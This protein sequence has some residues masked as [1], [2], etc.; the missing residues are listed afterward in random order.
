[1]KSTRLLTYALTLPIWWALLLPGTSQAQFHPAIA[2]SYEPSKKPFYFGV[3]SGDPRPN[4]VLLWTKLVAEPPGVQTVT[5]EI[6]TDTAMTEVVQQGVTTT[7]PSSAYTVK[8]LVNGLQPGTYYYYRFQNG[9]SYSAVGRTKTAPG[10]EVEQLRLAVVSCVNYTSGYFNALEHLAQR[11]DI[12]LVLHLGDYIYE[13]GGGGNRK[14]KFSRPHIPPHECI[15]LQD[16]RSRYAQ[17]RLDPQLQEAHRLHPFIIIW[18]D[19]ETANNSYATGAQNHDPR[20]EGSWEERKTAAVQAWLEWMP[21]PDTPIIRKFSFGK[22]ADLWMLDERLTAR[23]PQARG[24]DDPALEDSTRHM[25]GEQQRRWLLEGMRQSSA[26]WKLIGNQVIFSPLH[27][28]RVFSRNPTVRMDRWDGYPAERQRIFDFWYQHK[29]NNIIVLTGDVHT[30]WAFELTA[31]PLNPQAYNRKTGQG[32]IGAEF[33]TPSVS[34]FNFDE[35]VPKFMTWEAK[36][37]FKRKKHNPHLRYLDLNHHG[38]LT[39]SLNADEARAD[40]YFAKTILKKDP[41]HCHKGPRVLPWNGKR[42]SKR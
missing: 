13:Y 38:Y 24:L 37:R 39:L 20:S 22:L 7:D 27:D 32:V 25:I 41:R 30:S 6:A 26:R 16:Y 4:Q 12:D 36:R 2:A 33:T 5:W 1:M 14:K 18:D 34:S 28:S 9:G 35:V 15:T 29:L 40:W 21:I 8:V 23:S 11:K 3:A 42:L 19:H 17:Y 31:D 10:G